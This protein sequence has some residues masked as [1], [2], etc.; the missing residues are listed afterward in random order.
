MSIRLTDLLS[1]VADS[2]DAAVRAVAESVAEL[3]P[4]VPLVLLPV[5]LETRFGRI[6]VPATG[7]APTLVDLAALLAAAARALGRIGETNLATSLAGLSGDKK[8]AVRK[9]TEPA[10]YALLGKRLTDAAAGLE[11]ARV[12]QRDPL[13]AGEGGDAAVRKAAK[14]LRA[15]LGPAR[16]SVGRLRSDFQRDAFAA[17][18]E[19]VAALADLVLTTLEGR[20]L[21]AT[22]LRAELAAP[23][24]REALA[25][26]ERVRRRLS[27]ADALD[28]LAAPRR[29]MVAPPRLVRGTAAEAGAVTSRAAVL[30]HDQLADGAEAYGALLAALGTAGTTP[31]AELVA[32]VRQRAVAIP[33]VP[34]AWKQRLQDAADDATLAL[35]QHLREELL[36]TIGAI[37][38]DDP[39]LD[40]T[41]RD[42]GGL[43]VVVPPATRT[44][45]VLTVRIY[46]DDLVVDTHETALTAAE[47]D[48]GVAFWTATIAAGTDDE[49]RRAAWRGLCVGRSTRRAAWIAHRLT[50]KTTKPTTGGK[51]VAAILRALDDVEAAAGIAESRT[52]LRL[53]KLRDALDAL[54]A[55]LT[56]VR[57]LPEASLRTIRTRWRVMTSALQRVIER[58]P[59]PT[60]D[61]DA[62]AALEAII[63]R[64]EAITERIDALEP[65][66]A[67][68]P[69]FPDVGPLKEGAWTR[70]ARAGT[71]PDRFVVVAVRGNQIVHATAGSP[72]DP[73]LRLSI[74]PDAAQADTFAT[75]EDGNLVVG[76]A[77][78]WLVDPEEAHAKGM[79]LTLPITP[80]DAVAGFDRVYAIGVRGEDAAI[81]T[82]RLE[83]L[84]ENHH[85]GQKGL[86]L[87]APGTPTNNT[88]DARAGFS[89]TDDA[90][91]AYAVERSA[92]LFD[93]AAPVDAT[94]RDG[95]R[96]AAALG[97]DPAVL[98]HVEGADGRGV[99]E[100]QTAQR[101]L[102]AA[103]IGGWIEDHL[104]PL[105]PRRAR[106]RLRTFAREH[107][108]ASGLIPAFRVGQQPYGVLPTTAWSLLAPSAADAPSGQAAFERI[109]KRVLDELLADWRSAR[110]AHVRIATDHGTADAR[111]HFLQ[112][113]GL[114]PTSVAAG[115]RIAVNVAGRHGPPSLSPEL[116]FGLP[117]T[118]GASSGAQF[119]PYALLSRFDA[120]L[121]D[122]YGIAAGTPLR[123]P[124]T[125]LV[126]P[127]LEGVYGAIQESR[128]YEVRFFDH[129]HAL[130][131]PLVDDDASADVVA[132]LARDPASLVADA[133]NPDVR[134]GSLL[135]LLAR[136]A[137]LHELRRAALE[138]LGDQGLLAD[139]ERERAGASGSF[140]T[141]T[142]PSQLTPWS[143]LT[144]T[145]GS[146]QPFTLNA[147][148]PT[149]P[150]TQSGAP[151][152]VDRLRPGTTQGTAATQPY[153]AQVAA[154]AADLTALATLPKERLA[155][156]LGEVLDLSSHRLDP[157]I[158]GVVQRRL[159]SMRAARP[160]GAQLGAYGWVD[161]LRPDV[162]HPLATNVPASLGVDPSQPVFR[163]RESQGFVH[164]PSVNHAVTAAILRSGY[165]SQH[166]RPDLEN[167]MAVNLS[168]R[169]VRVAM[170]LIDGVRAG[171]RLGALLGYR[172]ERFLHE[173]HATGGPGAATLD[174]LI[175]PLRAAYP[176][177]AGVDS[178][179]GG[180]T[181]PGV[182]PQAAA[183]QVCDGLAIA[184]AV[185]AWAATSGAAA[186][187]ADRT[188]AD[189]MRAS[190]RPWGLAAAA[191]PPAG[192][193]LLEGFI[194]AVDHVVDALDAVA[195]LVVAE[196]VHQLARGNHARAAAA[197]GALA[198]GKAPPRPEIV[199]T[200]RT[201]TPLVHRVLLELPAGGATLPA[202]W[203]AIPLTPRAAAEPALNAWVAGL[204]GD[205]AQLRLA[206]VEEVVPP[207]VARAGSVAEGEV[208]EPTTETVH[209][210]EA[211]VVDLG[212]H[213]ID[214]LEILGPGH[215]TGIGELAA[216]ALD[217]RRPLEVSD[218]VAPPA[219]QVTLGRSPL[220][221]SDVTGIAELA[222][223]LESVA[224]LV[225]R[226]RAATAHDYALAAPG[227]TGGGDGIDI[228]DLAGRVEV[229]RAAAIG[230][231]VGLAQLL[232]DDP[233]LDDGVLETPPEAFLQGTDASVLPSWSARELWRTALLPAAA[234]GIPG[235][236]PPSAFTGRVP[237]RQALRTAAEIG[238]VELAR[239]LAAADAALDAGGGDPDPADLVAATKALFGESFPLVPL[240][241]PADVTELAS[242]AAAE[243]A[244]PADIDGWLQ[245]AGMVRDAPGA[246]A[247][248]LALADAAGAADL[249]TGT[250][251]Q[252]PHDP[253]G[254][255]PWLGGT[256]PPDRDLPGRLSLVRFGV[257]DAAGVSAATLLV[258]EWTEQLP[259]PSET[260]GVA[261]H[262]DQPDASPPQ[263]VLVAVPPVR[264]QP[265][266][267]QALAQVLHDTFDLAQIRAVEPDHLA[268]TM[269]G[270]LLPAIS[271]EVMPRLVGRAPDSAARPLVDFG[272]VRSG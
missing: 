182:D 129:L 197:L 71:L 43:T 90:D 242:A 157:W 230:A 180:A 105:V 102:Y 79:A 45:D 235:A 87:V 168:S 227:S 82:E 84:L 64:A 51:A 159:S 192:S 189:V 224:D 204:L 267:L 99:T 202:A 3:D 221:T 40:A 12:L 259:S 58:R 258:D 85:Y 164:A 70:A 50:P 117:S 261:I 120:V 161:D 135:A 8:Q 254:A 237:V 198:E 121:R 30:G 111:A 236:L 207:A 41:V 96:L 265:W 42:P 33:V 4:A 94:S 36:G 143:Y 255:E 217:A 49:A 260:T 263:A 68:E 44:Q 206:I 212:L 118:S 264:D 190:G 6:D 178:I 171:N 208:A 225:G 200:P 146:L 268:G 15:A 219:Q 139:D 251:C 215:D 46:P 148:W 69:T 39:K 115:Y 245:A 187:L 150:L 112:V 241:T 238:Y 104:S 271:G 103:T 228:A 75:D 98:A 144:E 88:E 108:A 27:A 128:A 126:H 166:D 83:A 226:S 181:P 179:D 7:T 97:V 20:T 184:D 223:L 47:H 19:A 9:E 35:P 256:V 24:V 154:H 203:A 78:R 243:L 91:A 186:G 266:T 89:S 114:Q 25:S 270:Q 116:R 62:R 1:A 73:D 156:L 201:G 137:Y 29:T 250:V 100:A 234:F 17:Q 74:D 174:A 193:P 22:Q 10:L 229:A 138:L 262:Y 13:L 220:W 16:A 5:R 141:G 21:P 191:V 247:D 109:L 63:E 52:A 106:E 240:A 257:R 53:Q 210:G 110:A 131:G 56:K 23:T 132:L 175:G 211:N 253:S 11:E 183:R 101:A 218:V 194:Q 54:R 222:P 233:A 167:R 152:L 188:L 133:W 136:Q 160:R 246:L 107:V 37:R 59:L 119:G 77:I 176:S 31:P 140:L 177:A 248:V 66:R 165:V 199:D 122:A 57:R 272:S 2:G 205:P 163:D 172:L 145:P 244:T 232:A 249:P 151:A 95:R 124:Q 60:L 239:R 65:E 153:A 72:V 14:E 26:R 216:R 67:P 130:R 142:W 196:G 81:S 231:A 123:D 92:P 113:L 158:T 149:H 32:E 55:L 125:G 162:G 34:A 252:L 213:P 209:V 155:T 18:L 38:S 61:P 173:F 195:D 76:D 269:Y 48:A 214:L 170:G 185:Q 169:R 86:G 134:S 93:A 28:G 127:A 147:A 80:Q